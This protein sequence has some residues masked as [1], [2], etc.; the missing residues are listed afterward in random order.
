VGPTNALL[1]LGLLVVLVLGLRRQTRVP[2]TNTLLLLLA[3]AWMAYSSRG[4]P[5]AAV[6]L[7]PHLAHA[8]QQG[9]RVR[10]APRGEG[11]IVGAMALVASA[12]LAGSVTSQPGAPFQPGSWETRALD[13]MPS[14]TVVLNEPALGGYLVW[15][16]PGLAISSY[17]Y[18][19]SY[20][21]AQFTT[22]VHLRDASPGWVQDVRASGAKV[23][24]LSTGSPLAR[25][26]IQTLH[27][28]VVRSDASYELLRS[29]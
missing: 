28:T 6:I 1:A 27:W 20:N 24:L 21:D 10:R 16:Y 11:W 26:L 8:L 15:R 14:G 7:V 22:Y 19:D 29:P 17:G 25:G 9:M 3:I 13:A 4:V 2:L 18:F 12:V 23:A 5:I